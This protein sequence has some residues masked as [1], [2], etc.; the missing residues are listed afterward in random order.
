M[1][2]SHEK[3]EHEFYTTDRWNNWLKQVKESG[4]EFKE[5]ESSEKEGAVFVNMTD[6][7]ILACLKVIAKYESNALPAEDAMAILDDIKEIALTEVEPISEDIDL[8]IESLQTSL[9]GSFA[10]FECYISKDFDKETD[11]GELINAAVESEEAEEIDSAIFCVAQVGALVLDGKKLPESSMEELPYGLVA[12]WL[13]GIDSI[14]AAMIG[15]DSYKE[16]DGEY[17]DA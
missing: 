2:E 14:E 10:G 13:D 11:I 15:S 4:F 12:E 6:D 16:D 17:D 3:I 7:V 9:M 5:E 1:P 8:M